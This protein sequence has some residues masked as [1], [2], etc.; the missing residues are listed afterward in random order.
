MWGAKATP[1][2]VRNLHKEVPEKIFDSCKEAVDKIYSKWKLE[3]NYYER[4]KTR[5]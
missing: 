3:N 4:T 5:H 2:P 1:Y